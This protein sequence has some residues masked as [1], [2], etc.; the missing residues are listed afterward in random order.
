MIFSRLLSRSSVCTAQRLYRVQPKGATL[1]RTVLTT[2]A[3][4]ANAFVSEKAR[5]AVGYWLLTCCGFTFG[6]IVVGAIT[7]ITK[8][9]LS[10]VDWHLFKEFPP[11]SYAQWEIEFEKYKQFPEYKLRNM[12]MSIEEFKKIWYMEYFHRMLGRNIGAVFV[13]PA[14][15]FWYK[16]WFT[17]G[18]K[19]RGLLGWYMVKSGLQDET[20][21]KY[22][23]PRVSHYRLAAHL[24]TAFV[25]YSLLLWT[26]LNTL[27][28]PEKAPI[29][30]KMVLFRK[31]VHSTK[32]L[33]FLTALSGALVAGLEAGLVYNSFPKMA[34]RWI[35]SDLFAQTPL[36]KNFF[37]NSTTVQF[38]HR[39]FGELVFCAVSG[40]WLYGRRLP[41][42][43]RMRLALNCL[44]GVACVQVSLGIATLLFYVPKSLAVT[45][46][47]GAL[48]L[49]ST[50][51]WL[52]H[53][54]KLIRYVKK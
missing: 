25:F 22:A 14:A 15:Y 34:D 12:N 6:T 11:L 10:M 33:I 52:G 37:E 20:A 27:F 36:W 35:P 45:H 53:E 26:G 51:L 21:Q 29:T 43:P 44:M 9:G 32:G 1:F 3:Q 8:S 4:P 18:M 16:K 46:Q 31:L 54:M 30:P 2:S 49:L 23:D 19:K 40:C 42:N 47:A 41:L 38:D 50:A 24:G 48:T 5:K 7:R 13:I 17:T 39:L 28:P